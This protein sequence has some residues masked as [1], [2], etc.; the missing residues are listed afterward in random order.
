MAVWLSLFLSMPIT[1]S[2]GYSGQGFSLRLVVIMTVVLLAW[3][4]VTYPTTF[5]A[6]VLGMMLGS[7]ILFIFVP[8]VAKAMVLSLLNAANTSAAFRFGAVVSAVALL[9]FVLLRLPRRISEAGLL[10][11][12]LGLL[13][14]LWYL[15]I[16]SAYAALVFYLPAWF[17]W[18]AHGH[19]DSLW[20][21]MPP[22]MLPGFRRQWIRYALVTLASV[23][24]MATLLP[25][26]YTALQWT[27]LQIW[28]DRHLP[29]LADLRGGETHDLRGDGGA[30]SIAVAGYGDGVRLGGSV[31][32][33]P[34]VLLEVSRGR[35]DYLRGSVWQEYTGSTWSTVGDLGPWSALEAPSALR[36]FLRSTQLEINH[37]RLRTVTVFTLPYTHAVFDLDRTI[38]LS[39]GYSV[40]A[41]DEVPRNVPYTVR[42]M[43]MA[44][45]GAFD[46]LEQETADTDLDL[47]LALPDTVS[48]E[49]EALALTLTDGHVSDYNKMAILESYL[50]QNYEYSKIASSLPPQTDFVHFFLFAEQKGYCT[51][52]A[53]ALAV[54]GRIAGVPTRYVQG[55]RMPEKAD[56]DG[57]YRVTGSD[58][59]AWVEAYIGGLGWMIFEATPVFPTTL[60]LPLQASPAE[61]G[62]GSTTPDSEAPPE[63]EPSFWDDFPFIIVDPSAPP[64][65]FPPIATQTAR[66]VPATVL[67]FL[68][69]LVLWRWRNLRKALGMIDSLPA[70]RREIAYYNL[71]L[72][73]LEAMGLGK[74]P[75]ETPREYGL[76]VNRHVYDWKLDFR[77]IS[78]GINDCLYGEGTEIEAGFASES[79]DFFYS[80]LNRY[81]VVSGRLKGLWELYLRQKHLSGKLLRTLLG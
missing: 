68:I 44:Y 71:S 78:E 69:A 75:S 81:M 30:F 58:A 49:V 50:R 26:G 38:Y 63:R 74:N 79:H 20:Q 35:S 36:P 51:S 19:G 67:L 3:L 73:L 45:R 28:A 56:Q 32:D 65:E 55:F 11:C 46:I 47:W 6:G 34:T 12:G 21:E 40:I 17:L 52:F 39:P 14:P 8:E 9:V 13:I 33:D 43:T 76:R 48:A 59:H 4:T 41:A 22:E 70:G 16:D 80:V 25:K 1:D 64:T 7:V 24:V 60:S 37:R 10:L 29:F 27:G 61:P 23:M 66:L 2:L 53:S 72:A 18:L 57:I 77:R 31:V 62:G 42:G 54:M 5:I 15:Y